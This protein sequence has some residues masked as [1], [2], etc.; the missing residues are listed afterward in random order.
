M[1]REA[2]DGDA[3]VHLNSAHFIRYCLTHKKRQKKIGEFSALATVI[4]L[5]PLSH[6][7][8]IATQKFLAGLG[9]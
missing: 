8:I 2:N 6:I 3:S 9:Y 1:S 4:G 5:C 7:A